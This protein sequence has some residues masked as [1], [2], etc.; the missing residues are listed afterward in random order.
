MVNLYGSL[1]T[2]FINKCFDTFRQECWYWNRMS[3]K[4][5]FSHLWTIWSLLSVVRYSTMKTRVVYLLGWLVVA[6]L[7]L[8]LALRQSKWETV[9]A[10]SISFVILLLW[11]FDQLIWYQTFGFHFRA[12][13]NFQAGTG[14][15]ILSCQTYFAQTYPIFGWVNIDNNN[16][17]PLNI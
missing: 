7:P 5:S 6:K 1:I 9:N 14:Q 8:P 11:Y 10:Q 16:V 12:A 17:E 15:I 3:W 2:V 4:W 13:N